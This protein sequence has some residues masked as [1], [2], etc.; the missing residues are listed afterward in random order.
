[1]LNTNEMETYNSPLISVVVASF[2]KEKMV[3]K[4][5]RSIQ[6]QSLKNIEIII[7][8]D[9]S[10][11]NSYKYYN[12]LLKT[13]SRIRIFYHLENMGV[14]RTR[15]DGFLYSKGNYIIHFDGGDLYE[16]NYVL[17]DAYN[18]AEKNHLDSVKMTFRIL[19]NYS[20]WDTYKLPFILKRNYSK[21]IYN[22][23][24]I[25]RYNSK[26]CGNYTN[27]WNRLIRSDIVLK[28]LNL[29]N[30]Y[31]LNIYKNL[32]E[33]IWWNRI[34]D[35]V[36]YNYAIINRFSYLYFKDGTGEG[37]FKIQTEVQKDRMIQEFIK[38]IK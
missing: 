3:M 23:K 16:D 31:I 24:N 36:S 17:E 12:Y 18:I 22:S 26:I 25:L 9:C 14:W 7:V 13:D 8:D 5:L 6:N 27:I 15:L 32:W 10:T 19:N 30:S 2:N 34:V 20:N 1:M 4:S 33:D 11:D 21:I 37:T 29:L 28:G 38:R 35:K